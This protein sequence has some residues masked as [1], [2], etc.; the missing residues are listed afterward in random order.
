[1]IKLLLA[2]DNK[3][4]LQYF[5]TLV[6]WEDYGYTLVPTA[7]DGE[8]AWYNFQKYA[9]DVVI[10]DIQMPVLSGIELARKV[11]AAAP[12]TVFLFLSSYREF[13]YAR[14]ALKLKVYDYLLKHE[15]TPEVLTAKLEEIRTH[16]NRERKKRSLLIQEELSALFLLQTQEGAVKDETES[17]LTGRYDCFFLEYDHPFSFL[18]EKLRAY[19]PDEKK[20]SEKELL[21][22]CLAAHHSVGAIALSDTRLLLLTDPASNPFDFCCQLQRSLL[23]QFG[24]SFRIVMIAKNQTV[25]ECALAFSGLLSFLPGIYFYPASSVIEGPYLFTQTEA[26]D[27]DSFFLPLPAVQKDT[28]A[29]IQSQYQIIAEQKNFPAFCHAAGQW[30]DLL[31]TY[32][33]RLI[34]PE[35]GLIVTLFS[36]R[37][38]PDGYDVDS[39]YQWIYRQFSL[40][41]DILAKSHFSGYSSIVQ[42]AV[43]L[44]SRHY[45]NY[46]LNVEW[47]AE[48]LKISP[49]GLNV[50]FKRETGHTPW[51]VIISTRLEEARNLLLQ[52]MEPS[53]VCLRTGYGS[54]SYFSKAFKKSYGVSPQDY[55]R[56]YSYEM[57]QT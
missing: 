41:A 54:L 32:H 40:V 16:L 13:Q 38:L 37:N 28:C 9:P 31:L 23:E 21:R 2:D 43:F 15:T 53:Q 27:A 26:A 39:V 34:Q 36:D 20:L 4:S 7:V 35:S 14:A 11:L 19:F 42:E 57:D 6:S 29:V 10:A 46:G 51:K 24:R 3:M 1:M 18:T 47:I 49:S 33:H 30:I 25:Q 17:V 48:Q 45:A 52:G 55:R 50:Q 5:S 56:N 12:D 22:F 8:S 44:I